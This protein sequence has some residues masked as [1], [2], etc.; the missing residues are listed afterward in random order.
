MS[1]RLTFGAAFWA[2]LIVSVSHPGAAERQAIS[3]SLAECSAVF[4]QVSSSASA[5]VRNPLGAAKSRRAARRF[6]TAAE[7]QARKEGQTH[8]RRLITAAL[9]DKREKWTGRFARVSLIE[10]NLDWV[11]YCTSLGRKKKVL[12]LPG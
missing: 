6:L 3:V 10:D 11:D 7:A 4:E 9:N 12:P 2:A 8:P 5:Q 1:D